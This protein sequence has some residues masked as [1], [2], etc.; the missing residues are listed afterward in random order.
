MWWF[1]LAETHHIYDDKDDNHHNRDNRDNRD[2]RSVK[3]MIDTTL[4]ELSLI[5]I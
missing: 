4:I 5:H 1:T 3:T 2:N